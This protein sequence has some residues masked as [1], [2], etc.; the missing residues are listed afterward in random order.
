MFNINFADNW[1]RTADLWCRKRPLYQLN[2]NH[3]PVDVL[4]MMISILTE[5]TNWYVFW[6]T[7]L[8][9]T[10]TTPGAS[11]TFK[12]SISIEEWFCQKNLSSR[13][14][15]MFKDLVVQRRVCL[16]WSLKLNWRSRERKKNTIDTHSSASKVKERES[17]K[18]GN[19]IIKTL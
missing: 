12:M 19:I 8:M 9:T 2:H 10:T 4:Y 16:R 1:I 14:K 17:T 13:E 5:M 15:N 6:R 7:I 3:C 18:P 11:F